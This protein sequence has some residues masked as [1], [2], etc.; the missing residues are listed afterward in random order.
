MDVLQSSLKLY[1][2]FDSNDS[3]CL[4]EDFIKLILVS[5]NP[6][7]DKASVLC[8]LNNLEKYEIIQSKDVAFKKEI[9]KVWTIERPLESIPQKIEVDFSLA[10]TIAKVIN[11]AA[12]KFRVKESVCDPANIT[13]QNLKDLI[14]LASMTTN[15]EDE[16]D[17]EI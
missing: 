14:I 13:N 4:E 3:F 12:V 5:D 1:E 16:L 15:P 10:L 11:E 17:N 7:R 2:W 6:E 8:A 9:K